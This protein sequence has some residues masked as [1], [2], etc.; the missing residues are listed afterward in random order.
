[1]GSEAE[2]TVV[3]GPEGLAD[4]CVRFAAQ[5]EQL[6]SRFRADSELSR[7]SAGEPVDVND[8]TREL[9]DRMR[10]AHQLTDG[11]FDPTLLR[12]VIELGYAESM[13]DNPGEAVPAPATQPSNASIV[14]VDLSQQPVTL[15]RGLAVD[16]GGIGK[17]FAADLVCGFVQHHGARGVMASLGGDLAVWGTPPDG[18]D[19][20]IDVDNATAPGNPLRRIRLSSGA[21]ATSSQVK[22]RFT[23]LH[24]E[25][26]HLIHPQ[27]RGPVSDDVVSVTAIAGEGWF[28]EACTKPGFVWSLTDYLRWIPTVN[29]A[30]LVV[31][32]DGS[33]HTSANWGCYE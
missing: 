20:R 29:A 7:L 18:P 13:V 14:D 10:R 3:G 26:S 28:A 27:S 19:W 31:T 32:A 9:F 30:A 15:P 21:V 5:L 25:R 33:V 11:A 17:G 12:E 16:A 23:S 8:L 1:M 22:R 2:F 6:W 24:G 4:N